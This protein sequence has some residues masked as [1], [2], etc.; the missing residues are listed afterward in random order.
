MKR[1]NPTIEI[2]PGITRRTVAHGNTMYQMLATLAAGSQMPAH[3][4]PT[5]ADRSHSRRQDA[6][7]VE[8]V[9]HELSAGD[10]FYL[11]SNVPHGVETL[12]ATR[13]LNTFSP[14]R[15]DY[16]AIDEKVLHGACSCSMKR[17]PRLGNCS[18]LRSPADITR[19]DPSGDR[20]WAIRLSPSPTQGLECCP[21][22]DQPEETGRE[23]AENVG[24]IMGSQINPGEPDEQ[25]PEAGTH[26]TSQTR[27]TVPD[28]FPGKQCE[29]TVKQSRSHGV[30]AGETVA[31]K[32][33]QRVL[34]HGAFAME[35]MFQN[36]VER[37]AADHDERE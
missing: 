22:E 7:I 23:R 12:S 19:R 10:S 9:P 34:Q 21:A 31:G 18:P 2:C 28:V 1:E 25:D 20:S 37:A 3:S 15:T 36:H 33:H 4:H 27:G 29:E 11:A 8:G 30:P 35:K 6:L 17:K 16:L 14:P 26:Y 5:G 13:V 32:R 24:Q